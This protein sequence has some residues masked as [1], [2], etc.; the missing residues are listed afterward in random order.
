MAKYLCDVIV[1]LYTD[2]NYGG[3]K[4]PILA[5]TPSLTA[6]GFN[7]RASS[8]RVVPG[9]AYNPNVTYR[10]TCYEH[11]NFGG[12]PLLLEEEY[13]GEWPYLKEFQFN[14]RISSVRIVRYL[15]R[16]SWPLT[17][18]P[19]KPI[20]IVVQL[21]EHQNYQGRRLNVIENIADLGSYAEFKD[22]ASSLQI[23]QATDYQWV[24]PNSLQNSRARLFRETHFQPSNDPFILPTDSQNV[25]PVPLGG[26]FIRDLSQLPYSFNECPSVH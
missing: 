1:M 21:Y 20:P 13:R 9:P 26:L 23:H 11:D 12:A 6:Y 2:S 5:S 8:I 14:D 15:P 4:C 18:S 7:D 3:T 10:I 19:I 24:G 17:A 25:T 16:K 22:K